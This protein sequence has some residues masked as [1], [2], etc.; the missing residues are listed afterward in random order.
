MSRD[1]M[2][3]IEDELVWDFFFFFFFAVCNY[4]N[5]PSLSRWKRSDNLMRNAKLLLDKK[6][7]RCSCMC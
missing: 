2:G 4:F 7:K 1:E 5:E 3:R 6:R